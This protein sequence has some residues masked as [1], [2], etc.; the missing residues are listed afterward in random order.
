MKSVTVNPKR[1]PSDDEH[2]Q[3][4]LVSVVNSH[5]IIMA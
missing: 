4:T 2:V 3:M 5:V 1:N